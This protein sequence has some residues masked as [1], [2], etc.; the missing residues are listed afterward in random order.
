MVALDGTWCEKGGELA[1]EGLGQLGTSEVGDVLERTLRRMERHLGRRGLLRTLEDD[2]S[3]SGEGDP[4]S[5]LAASAYR[6]RRRRR[7]RSG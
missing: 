2:A 5:N 6:A 7:G 4:E 1:W 3:S